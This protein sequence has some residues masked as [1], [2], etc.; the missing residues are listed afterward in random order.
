MGTG[1]F[2]KSSIPSLFYPKFG[3]SSAMAPAQE[4]FP[5]D[6]RQCVKQQLC[7]LYELSS[8]D[9]DSLSAFFSAHQYEPRQTVFYEGN[10]CHG[11]YL[12]CRGK[13]KLVQTS[14][15]GQQ[16][17]LKIVTAGEIIDKQALFAEGPHVVT[18]EA[19]EPCLVG[20][21]PRERLNELLTARPSIALKLLRAMGK[22]L[23]TAYQ[24]LMTAT[25]HS[26]RER[27]AGT[28]LQLGRRHGV[29]SPTG[30][31]IAISLTREELAE[32]AGISVET[33]VRLLTKFKE[34]ELI[35]TNG[36]EITLLNSDRLA[37][38]AHTVPSAS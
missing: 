4:P 12:L 1:T 9:S 3:R 6:C 31:L 22:E 37:R 5:I 21:L 14:W 19:L 30:L 33:A 15:S 11:L 18:C 29:P 26:A 24:K 13:A 28:L 32:L 8:D 36:K 35:A 38:I 23:R 34:E 2:D 7:E 16:Q 25:F 27:M 17:I 20:F 10:P